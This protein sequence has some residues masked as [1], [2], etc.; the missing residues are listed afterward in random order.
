[1]PTRQST[2]LL[3]PGGTIRRW[4]TTIGTRSSRSECPAGRRGVRLV[5]VRIRCGGKRRPCLVVQNDAYN[6]RLDNTIVAQITSNLRAAGEPTHLLVE[7]NSPEGQQSGL[8]HDSLVAC[9][10]L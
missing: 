8:L 5:P 6:Q 7:V 3:P 9:I 4:T 2:E 1:M 10:N